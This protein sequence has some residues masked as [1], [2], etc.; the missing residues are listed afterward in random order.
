MSDETWTGHRDGYLRVDVLTPHGVKIGELAGVDAESAGEVTRSI[1]QEIRGTGT[2][3][4]TGSRSDWLTIRLRPVFVMTAPVREEFPLGVF[5]PATPRGTVDGTTAVSYAVDLYDRSK[6]LAGDSAAETYVVPAGTPIIP[7]VRSLLEIH[8]EGLSAITDSPA[9]V[10]TP[11]SWDPGTSWLRII[12]DLLDAAGFFALDYDGYGT[13]RSGPYVK[14]AD[15]PLQWTFSD[16]HDSIRT[17]ALDI[18][19]DYFDLYNRVRVSAASAGDEM[20][21]T[22][23]AENLDVGPFS[24]QSLGRWVTRTE[25]GVDAANL[26]ALQAYA[27]RLLARSQE[28]TVGATVTHGWLPFLSLNDRVRVL[29]GPTQTDITGSVSKITI[30]LDPTDL[31]TAQVGSVTSA[32]DWL[33]HLHT[34]PEPPI[35]WGV[36]TATN[37]LRIRRDG[38]TLPLPA[39]PGAL[40]DVRVDDRVAVMRS[41]RQLVV[42]GK[43]SGGDNTVWVGGVPYQASGSVSV[44]IPEWAVSAPPIYS[45]TASF[46]RPYEP[47]AGY[48]FEAHLQSSSVFTVISTTNTAHASSSV[49]FHVIQFHNASRRVLGIGWRLT[50]V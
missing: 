32:D 17:A 1:H 27:D 13:A 40:A 9:T 33:T 15:R 39:A 43:T 42:I 46:A 16:G 44:S 2:V 41:G 23:Q 12:N 47:P 3:N 28:I 5:L 22:A 34:P 6:V 4:V 38:D 24:R 14:P 49:V 26:S 29:D 10:R 19:A 25:T 48:G 7:H 50:K 37:P 31:A 20:E 36:V 30:P 8:G 35:T 11:M 45:T 18:G 21:L